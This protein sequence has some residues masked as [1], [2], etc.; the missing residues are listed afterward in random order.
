MKKILLASILLCGTV[1]TLS[2]QEVPQDPP[3]DNKVEHSFLWG[4]FQSDGYDKDR[5]TV[6]ET[7]ISGVDSSPATSVD[8]DQYEQKSV[9]WGAIQWTEKKKQPTNSKN[10]DQ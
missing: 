2:A 7:E 1:L 9:L 5:T 4:L 6:F 8:T 10:D 3:K